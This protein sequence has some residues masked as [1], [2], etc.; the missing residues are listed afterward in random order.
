MKF[1]IYG[2][3]ILYASLLI[4]SILILLKIIFPEVPFFKDA[5]IIGF[6]LIATLLSYFVFILMY[7]KAFS[8]IAKDAYRKSSKKYEQKSLRAKKD[9]DIQL[10][11]LK[12]REKYRREF[13]GNVSHELKTPLFTIQSY[14]LTLIDGAVKDKKIRTNYL[15][16]INKSVDR[17]IYIVRDLDILADIES[18]NFQLDKKPLYLPKL[19]KEVFDFLEIKAQ[20]Q[21]VELVLNNQLEPND[22]IQADQERMEQVLTNLISNSISYSSTK[23]NAKVEMHLFSENEQI[24]VE[25]IDNGQGIGK[26]HQARIFERFYRTDAGRSRDKGGS[27]LG[28]AIVKNIL[29]AHDSTISLQSQLGEGSTFSFSFDRIEN[30]PQN[31]T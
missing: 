29:E 8:K 25:V 24:K 26:E 19:V 11:L 3:S 1:S 14:I 5:R 30:L 20:E 18:G 31:Q 17:L 15:S 9:K 23:E 6:F 7:K 16:R 13:L 10:A 27:G 4:F 28:L 2:R 21:H 22:F 12:D